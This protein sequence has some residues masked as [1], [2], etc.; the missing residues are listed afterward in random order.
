MSK[1]PDHAQ[2]EDQKEASSH[3]ADDKQQSILFKVSQRNEYDQ[4]GRGDI[5]ERKRC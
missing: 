4:N 5:A 2:L 3:Q 1:L